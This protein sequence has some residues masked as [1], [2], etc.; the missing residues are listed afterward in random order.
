MKT[1]TRILVA[2]SGLVY[3]ITVVAVAAP[4]QLQRLWPWAETEGITS[5]ESA[6]ASQPARIAAP[7]DSSRVGGANEPPTPTDPA[8][9]VGLQSNP[10]PA[11]TE[12]KT[13]RTTVPV[14]VGESTTTTSTPPH[15]ETSD[16]PPATSSTGAPSTTEVNAPP[17]TTEVNTAETAPS[18][19]E[20]ET[21]ETARTPPQSVIVTGTITESACPCTVTG[22]VELK[23]DIVLQGDLMVDGGALVARPGVT[24]DGNGFQI[25]FM[26]GGRADFQGTPTSTWSGDGSNANLSRDIEFRN[27]RRIMFHD[28][29]GASTLRYF[30]VVDSGTTGVLGDYPLHW[31]HNGDSVRGTVVEGVV[32]L[33]G[34]N[35][36]FVPHGSHGITFRDI[37]AKNIIE[38][39]F[40]WDSPIGKED[41]VGSIHRKFHTANNSN[42]IVVD[43][44]L[45][46]GVDTG[47][48]F[49]MR[50]AAY[51]LGAGTGNV[52]KNSVARNVAS[53]KQCSGFHWPQESN[54][55]TGGNLWLFQNN[56]AHNPSGCSGIFVWQ[57]DGNDHVISDFRS[58]T[59]IEHGAYLNSYE[60][61]NVDVPS[62]TG[63]ALGWEVRDSNIGHVTIFGHSLEGGPIKFTNVTMSSFVVDNSRGVGDPKPGTY[64]LENTNLTCSGIEIRSAVPGTEIII[65]GNS[66]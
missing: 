58:T 37:I 24:L 1:S 38:E 7:A 30:R 9:L 23:G 14:E 45:V 54:Q 4:D 57:N 2:T 66:C 39:A 52:I 48:K 51:E 63:H 26:N 3:L 5:I 33:N 60:Y 55:N 49:K 31:H 62:F 41:G 25:M 29:A 42:D 12:A 16:V 53:G 15:T 18:T 65:D 50:I 61:R 19:T 40:W 36:A 27:L 43:H 34:R 35:H 13:A 59:G 32:V 44:A 10:T 21:A 64:V 20:V 8:D 17:S 47:R 22:S 46:D 28:N 6:G 11:S 56:A